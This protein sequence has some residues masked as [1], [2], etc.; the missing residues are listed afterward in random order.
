[1]GAVPGSSNMVRDSRSGHGSGMPLGVIM[2]THSHHDSDEV[3]TRVCSMARHETMS[4]FDV[5]GEEPH[6][7]W[8]GLAPGRADAAAEPRRVR[9]AGRPGRRGDSL[10]A[11]LIDGGGPLPSLILWGPPGTGKTTLARLLARRRGARFVALSAVFSG[12]KEVRAAI[13]EAAQGAAPRRPHGAVHR[14]DP[15]VQQG[16]AGRAAAGRRGRHDHPHRRHDREPLVRGQRRPALP[17]PGARA[18]AARPRTR[19]RLDPAPGPDGRRAGAWPRS[20]R[21]SPTRT[22]L[23][24]RRLRRR[25]TPGWP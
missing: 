23:A 12:V 22:R 5:S 6:A 7:R 2:C 13:D 21:R 15:P 1:M 3:I 20:G 25:A 18:R 9:R 4:L 8:C 10:L 16:P 11:R 14:R 17:L 24:A 19:S